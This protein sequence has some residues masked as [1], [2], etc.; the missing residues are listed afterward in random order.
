MAF[1]YAK[2]IQGLIANAEDE[3]LSEE[4]RATYR[5]KAEDLMRQYRIAEE[6]LLAHD[7]TAVS[8]I[9]ETID[10]C[11]LYGNEF[12]DWY[13]TMLAQ[14]ARHTGCRVAQSYGEKPSPHGGTHLALQGTLVGHE[15]D[16]AYA[17]FLWTAAKL[18]F[19][20]RVDVSVDSSVSDQVNAY[21]LRG[22]G[23][24]RAETANKL[25]GSDFKDGVAHGRVQKL[26]LAEC[27]ARGEK[28]L[29]QGRGVS[30]KT[31]REVY[32]REF[33]FG[34][35]RRLR[36]AR[37]AADSVGGGLV[38][39]GREERVDE[40]FYTLF[41]AYR[42]RPATPAGEPQECPQC[43][44]TKSKSG[45][46]RRHTTKEYTQAEMARWNRLYQSPAA[47]AG[48]SAGKRAS[49]AVQ[50]QRGHQKAQRAPG[51]AERGQLPS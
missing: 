19:V 46:C 38:L 47:R 8:I 28:P 39:P 31:Y 50:I 11:P 34:V 17:Q 49:D 35:A 25:W 51:A 26:Y 3:A 45:K 5:R 6:E 40:A 22:S 42:P 21:F 24:S 20:T 12:R 13:W 1:D 15:G 29:V 14:I 30:A 33:T 37:D 2:K 9:S 43:K 41:P 4:V 23:M 36:E 32:A 7:A 27:E 16:V 44:V 18:M 10:I 48:A